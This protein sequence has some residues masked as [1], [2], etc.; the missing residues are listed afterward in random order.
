MAEMLGV[1][2][3]QMRKWLCNRKITTANEVLVKPLTKKEVSVTSINR[4]VDLLTC[5]ESGL[6]I[7][8]VVMLTV[9]AW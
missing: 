7:R 6:L 3:E 9:D 5:R 1:D 8:S 2:G 4:F